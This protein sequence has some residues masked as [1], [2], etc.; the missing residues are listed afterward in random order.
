[1]SLTIFQH[2]NVRC[3][4]VV[5]SRDFYTRV[6]GL[7]DGPRP[8]FP[9]K[10]YWLYLAGTPVVHLVQQSVAI[11]PSA[12]TGRIDHIAFGALGLEDTRLR[13][14]EAGVA[15]EE[16]VVPMDGT[17]QLFLRDP[18]GVKIELNFEPGA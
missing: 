16:R 15:F 8:P 9:S 18:D 17:T 6:I 4:D 11:A 3:S 7:E 2:V 12:G 5:G 10:G 14:R 1:M 13:L